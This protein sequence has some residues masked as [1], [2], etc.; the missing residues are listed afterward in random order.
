[1]LHEHLSEAIATLPLRYRVPVVLRDV[2]G[3]SYA[4]IARM[5]GT[6]PGTVKSRISRARQQL[7]EKLEPYVNGARK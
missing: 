4:D 5:T 6:Q 2:E 3:W 7:K 1:E